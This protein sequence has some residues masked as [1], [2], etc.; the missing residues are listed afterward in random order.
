MELFIVFCVF[1]FF[2]FLAMST[3]GGRSQA[4]DQIH[5]PVVT[6]AAAVT[7]PGSLTR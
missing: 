2:F 7:M 3:A 5:A 1:F 4:K 6:Q